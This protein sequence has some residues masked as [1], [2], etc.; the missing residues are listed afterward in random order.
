M[1]F[2][3]NSGFESGGISDGLTVE[4]AALYIHIP[5]CLKKCDYCDF[6]S[7]V[8]K[9]NCKKGGVDSLAGLDNSS[10]G[11]S[12]NRLCEDSKERTDNYSC[13]KI[14]PDSYINSLIEEA[15]FLKSYF[16]TKSF[17]TVYI[18]GGTP[19]L[20]TPFQIEHL[21]ENILKLSETE[22]S[23]ITIEANPQ[24]LTKEFLEALKK[25]KI[26][27]LSLGIQTF[28]DNA[29][30][31]IGRRGSRK[32]NL[33]ALDLVNEMWEGRL[34]CDLIAGLPG[35]TKDELFEGLE[36]LT[37]N[38][39]VDHISLYSLC[40]EEG[41]PLFEK[42][43]SG[44]ID[45]DEDKSDEIWIEGRKF[46]ESRGFFQYEVSNFAKKGFESAHNM[47]YWKQE[48]YFGIGSG[49]CGT[50]YKND[51]G[52]GI[53][54]FRF[55]GKKLSELDSSQKTG[56]FE[57]EELDAETV[58]FEYLM[59]GLRTLEGICES[60][61]NS[62]FEKL[63]GKLEDRLKDAEVDFETYFSDGKKFFTLGKDGILFLNAVLKNL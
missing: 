16:K 29:L 35:T 38:P 18:G 31:T 9:N 28:S 30:K 48:N 23:E 44:K 2:K 59:M 33:E 3:F 15:E 1:D 56:F 62:K 52:N 47:S 53:S 36:I 14:I 51:G 24:D 34:S 43:D 8:C 54:G 40:V 4:R 25:S 39:K 6:Y 55:T 21:L 49:G 50:V 37:A 11:D 57:T 41:T 32:E 27:R 20:L 17:S 26:N 12:G 46:L 61:Y 45:F 58:E 63:T 19:S 22:P 10:S 7:V 5:F 60:D 13:E 42:I